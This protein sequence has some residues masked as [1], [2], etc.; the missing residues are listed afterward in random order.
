VRYASPYEGS[1]KPIEREFDLVVLSVGMEISQAVRD[2]GKSLGIELDDYGF[3]STT[4]FNPLQT[5]RPG[6]FAAGPFREPKDIPETVTEA[7]GAAA[8]AAQLLAP[9]RFT[10]TSVPE[11]PQMRDVSEEA[12]RTGVFVCHCGSNIGGYLDVPSVAKYAGCLPGV[13]HAED[14][15][16]TCSQNTV[17]H[18][19]EQVRELGLNRV[20]VASCTPLTHEGMF[21]DALRQAG[22]NPHLFEMANIRN[23]CSWIHSKDWDG[24]TQKK[25]KRWF[26]WRWARERA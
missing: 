4:L 26:E 22:L 13:V 12:P 8:A 6:M 19:I 24:A 10:L 18:I 20:V 2:L 16:Y 23:Q 21:Q 14:N 15:L 5:S 7:S 1:P 17:E 3:C 9:A 25:P 11:Y